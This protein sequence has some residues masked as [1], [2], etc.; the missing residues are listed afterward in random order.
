MPP[1][2]KVG[3]K[4]QKAGSQQEQARIDSASIFNL[5]TASHTPKIEIITTRFPRWLSCTILP[6]HRTFP[7]GG[8]DLFGIGS[9]SLII[10]R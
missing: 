4:S 2:Y 10:Y 5:Y 7:H 9:H 8:R 1:P 6:R 3:S